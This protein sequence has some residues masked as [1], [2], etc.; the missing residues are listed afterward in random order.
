MDLG[1]KAQMA[2]QVT[3]R[4]GK[5]DNNYAACVEGLD[6]FVCTADT[7]DELK[8]EVEA[9]IE[10]HLEGLREDGDPIPEIFKGEYTLDFKWNVE[11]LLDYYRGIF[12]LAALERITGINQTQLG[13]Y[14]AGRSKPRKQQVEKIEKAL[15]H[16]GEELCT[17]SL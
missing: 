9:G 8:K 5:T 15:H 13:H 6:G 14:A 3:V 7:F 4:V 11:G 1:T 10:F 2:K 12:T 17:I 16:L